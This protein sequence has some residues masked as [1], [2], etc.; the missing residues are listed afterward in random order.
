MTHRE[1]WESY[2]CNV[3]DHLSSIFTDLGVA[4]IAPLA[5]MPCLYWL[6]IKLR[7][8]DDRGLSTDRE[9]DDLSRF[10]DEL[11]FLLSERDDVM[12]VG[13][14]T[15]Q[16]RREFYLYGTEQLN[17]KALFEPLL[18]SRKEYLSQV[19]SK[20]DP[21]WQQYVNVLYPG[22][23]GIEQINKRREAASKGP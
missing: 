20:A 18:D 7:F 13:R 10:E 4:A 9:F 1:D 14:V 17:I 22:D 12:Y 2:L 11:S 5:E 23:H 8:P 3:N 19:G 16:E 15:G 21:N 6:W